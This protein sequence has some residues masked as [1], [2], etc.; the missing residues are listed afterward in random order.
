MHG[1]DS[2]WKTFKIW[3]Q[4]LRDLVDSDDSSKWMLAEAEWRVY[5]SYYANM[6]AIA[7][8][9]HQPAWDVLINGHQEMDDNSS[10]DLLRLLCAGVE[11]V[12]R[13]QEAKDKAY[14]AH[15]HVEWRKKTRTWSKPAGT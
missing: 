10:K 5:G 11:V 13:R 1:S 12:D 14:H 3:L 6:I 9:A 4:N 15:A 7:A 8:E 2:W